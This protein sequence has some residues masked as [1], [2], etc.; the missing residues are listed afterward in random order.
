LKGGVEGRRRREEEKGGGEGRRRREWT[1]G[2]SEAATLD[3]LATL[4]LVR[5][6]R[7][8]FPHDAT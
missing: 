2:A 4:L 3:L 1:Q 7:S 8:H 5:I 6:P